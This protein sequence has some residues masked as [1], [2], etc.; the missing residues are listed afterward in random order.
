MPRIGPFLATTAL[1]LAGL[2]AVSAPAHADTSR[3]DQRI[4]NRMD[5]SRLA[6][7][8]DGVG[9]GAQAVSLRFPPWI[10]RTA[11]WTWI[12]KSDGYWV[13][14]NEA[15]GKCLQPINGA[16]SANDL[17]VVKTCDGSAL[18]DWSRVKEDT[19]A[20][21]ETGWGRLRPRTNTALALTLS[22]YQGSGVWDSL[23]LDQDQSSTDR[24]W[25][26][27]SGN[28]PW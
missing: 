19:V 12:T 6:L 18:Q 14:K 22:I 2:T 17:V 20:G 10:Y 8:G 25:R 23:Y 7:Y 4:I 27:V 13:L 1:M 5:G 3:S 15:A 16:P 28:G 21:G 24:L 9:E 26:A 11:K